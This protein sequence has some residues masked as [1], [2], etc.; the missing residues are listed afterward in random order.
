MNA[1]FFGV[2]Y[3]QG[4]WCQDRIGPLYS[5]RFRAIGNVI[6]FQW[7]KALVFSMKQVESYLAEPFVVQ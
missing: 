7:H 4:S 5:G 3:S 6:C 1:A 2:F